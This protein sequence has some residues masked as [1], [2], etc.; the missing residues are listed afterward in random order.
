QGM[1]MAQYLITHLEDAG[2]HAAQPAEAIATLISERRAYLDELRRSGTLKDTARLRPSR[3]SKR[4]RLAEGK[5]QVSEG[6]FVGENKSFAG[7]YWVETCSIEEA[8]RIAQGC[9]GLFGDEF[10]VRPLMKGSV[11]K[12]KEA[13]PGKLFVC[14][15]LGNA[16]TEEGWVQVMDRIDADTQGSFPEAMFLGGLRLQSP[17]TGKRV[18]A[19]GERRAVFDGP[20]L[21]SKEVIGGVFVIRT[22]S[23]DEAVRWAAKTR[24]IVHG[25][26]EIREL[27]RT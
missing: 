11:P 22:T 4:V 16:P 13:N 10:D 9:P 5:V 7:Y 1:A 27:W 19:Q 3:E 20:F 14:A 23:I 21:E 24:F 2:E 25:A 6:P 17:K 8:T 15:V 18:V 26:L 12:D